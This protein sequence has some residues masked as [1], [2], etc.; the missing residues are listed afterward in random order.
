M[1]QGVTLALGSSSQHEGS[2]PVLTGL[3]E[4]PV[5]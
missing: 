2:L 5:P 4:A 3:T 1:S